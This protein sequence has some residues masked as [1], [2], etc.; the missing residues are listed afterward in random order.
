MSRPLLCSLGSLDSYYSSSPLLP[1]RAEYC[2]SLCSALCVG[3]ELE[4]GHLSRLP[5]LNSRGAG[6]LLLLGCCCS[7]RG[8]GHTPCLYPSLT[9]RSDTGRRCSLFHIGCSTSISYIIYHIY[10][11]YIDALVITHVYP[12]NV[13]QL[14]VVQNGN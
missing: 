9:C 12:G 7:L 14:I 3:A 13:P 2:G 10:L 8:S 6:A 4:A 1:R 11:T 5:Y